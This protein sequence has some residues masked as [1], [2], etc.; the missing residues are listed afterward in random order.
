[1]PHLLALDKYFAGAGVDA[2]N[3]VRA[4]LP[5]PFADFRDGGGR[6]GSRDSSGA[7]ARKNMEMAPLLAVPVWTE[8]PKIRA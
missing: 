8:D 6:G 3:G 7:V 1:V 2:N 4:E 5:F